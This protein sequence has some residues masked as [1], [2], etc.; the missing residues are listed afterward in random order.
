M[1]ACRK[2]AIHY[3]NRRDGRRNRRVVHPYGFLLGH[4]HYLIGFHENPKA[5]HVAPFALPNIESV[6]IMEEGFARDPA[7][8]LA[9]YAERSFGL[10]Q[11]EPFDV[12][13]KF[14]PEAAPT[15]REFVFHTKQT[16]EMLSDGSLIVRFRAGGWLEMAWHLFCWGD[17]VEVLEPGQLAEAMQ[18]H[19]PTWPGLP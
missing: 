17:Q 4:R 10:F 9:A 19:R 2:V 16:Q 8:S 5:N 14:K 3:R 12:A 15:A 1:K 7:F 6:E 18:N 13:W 11:E